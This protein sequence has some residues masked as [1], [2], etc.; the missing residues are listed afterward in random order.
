[1]LAELGL[2]SWETIARRGS[3]MARGK[4]SP[5]EYA[6]MV[7]EKLGAAQRSAAA[8]SRPGRKPDWLALLAPWHT[9]AKSNARRL[10]RK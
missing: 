6:R 9:R 2:A 7:T 5:A 8:L 3:L 10:R 4:C 1:M